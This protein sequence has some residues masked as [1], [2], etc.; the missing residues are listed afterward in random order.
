MAGTYHPQNGPAN[1]EASCFTCPEGL[2]GTKGDVGPTCTAI[3][4]A[5]NFCPAGTP[6]TDI[7]QCQAGTYSFLEGKVS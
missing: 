4:P 6:N 2:F 3:C 7:P 1:Y 5:G